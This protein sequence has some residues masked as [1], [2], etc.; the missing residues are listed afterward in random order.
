MDPSPRP[1][2]GRLFETLARTEVH[3]GVTADAIA[4]I[5]RAIQLGLGERGATARLLEFKAGIVGGPDRDANVAGGVEAGK[6][7]CSGND[8]DT[9]VRLLGQA[10]A[11]RTDAETGWSLA[12]ALGVPSSEDPSNQDVLLEALQVARPAAELAP[13]AGPLAWRMVCWPRSS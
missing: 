10:W 2:W 9:A 3:L 11:L 8:S 5:D 13:M 7:A 12:D 1:G 6:S 4:D